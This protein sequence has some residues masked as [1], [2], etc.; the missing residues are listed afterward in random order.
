MNKYIQFCHSNNTEFS[1]EQQTRIVADFLCVM[2]DQSQ[3]PESVIKSC[4]AAIN[5]LFEALGKNSPVNN[6]DVRRLMS[7]L[8]KSG[9][10][11]PMKRSQPMPTQ[12]FND[13]FRSWGNNE[14]LSLKQLRMKTITLLALVCMSRPSDLA[15]KGIHF[16]PKDL[17]VNNI[18]LSL[19]NV[20][21]L[22]DDSLTIHFF[23]IKND[24]SRSGFEV[25]I[26]SNKDNIVMDPVTCLHT[27]IDRTT[28]MRPADSK[29]LFLTLTTP[30][31]AIS[32]NTVSNIL[33]EVISLAGLANRGFSAKS[34]RPTGATHAVNSGIA[35]ETVMQIG[36]WKT[37]EVFLNHYVYP[38][39]PQSFT[40]DILNK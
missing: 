9:T 11:A 25:N 37:R 2:S 24:T 19:D 32:S 14:D 4:A 36:R 8:I 3:R 12:P 23:G 20:T 6:P 26:P 40:S 17:S 27:Y 31:K 29:P 21:F 13:L 39:A 1:D 22:P 33:D 5:C 35:P 34:F 10:T 16:D 30:Y 28:P 15:P 38:R 18:L 7:G